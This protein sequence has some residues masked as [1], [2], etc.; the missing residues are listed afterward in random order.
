MTTPDVLRVALVQRASALGSEHVDP[1]DENLA[2]AADAI[3]VAAAA[4]ARLVVFGELYLTGYRTDEWLYKW[5]TT[6][7]PTDRHVRALAEQAGRLGVHVIIGAATIGRSVPGD[8]YN[9]AIVV[10]PSAI[11]GVYRKS[12]VAA[13]S[14]GE[15]VVRE[16][17]FYSPGRELPVFETSLGRLGVHICYDVAYP[18][19]ARVQTLRGADV[20]INLSAPNAGYEEYW[21]HMTYAR[22]VENANWYL[23]CSIVGAQRD[24]LLFGGSRIVSPSG[25]VVAQAAYGAEDLLV[26]DVDL[27][28]ARRVR[29]TTHRLSERQPA[30]Y[31]PITEP[32]PHP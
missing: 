27:A 15:R 16:R 2:R 17:S 22:A 14:D 24:S 11:A 20:L 23:V 3:E 8:L 7:D 29:A 21:K 26:A 1:R 30:L 19:V 13:F 28:V 32:T 9:S 12:H 25:E 6:V 4:G 18:E 10:A 31:G 5:A